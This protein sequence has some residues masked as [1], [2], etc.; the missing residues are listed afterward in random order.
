VASLP[1]IEARY[2]VSLS[3]DHVYSSAYGKKL[4]ADVYLPQ[5]VKKKLPVILWLHGGGWRLGDR[6]L[7]PDLS[8]FF[9]ECGFAMISIEY[10]LSTEAIFPAQVIDVKTAI[11][12]TRSVAGEFPFDEGRIGLWGSSSGGHLAACAALTGQNEFGGEEHSEFSNSVQA[13][14]DGYGPTDFSRMDAA[15]LA[16]EQPGTDRESAAVQKQKRTGDADSFESLLI[17]A[18]VSASPQAVQRA[19]PITY[20]HPGAP[21]FLILHGQADMLVPWQQS[22]LLFEAL[23]AAENDA[24]LMLLEKLG[25]GFLNNSALDTA[26]HGRVTLH[27]SR[28]VSPDPAPGPS[29][30]GFDTIETFFRK[31]LCA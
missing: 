8:R 28:T 14:V 3:T 19:N 4:L 16:P 24:T 11:R 17:G 5:G 10:R 21:P 29:S 9:A 1:E 6:K 12:W 26:D 15:R 20:M 18:P 25:H 23:R 27:S 2:P 22:W 13:V 30:F 7:A 31:H